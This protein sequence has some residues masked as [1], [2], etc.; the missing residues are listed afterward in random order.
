MRIEVEISEDVTEPEIT[1]KCRE[2]TAVVDRLVAA[3]QM[4]DRQIMVSYKGSI[5][6]LGLGEILY[7]ESVDGKSFVY[8]K[9]KI[10]ESSCKLYE[11]EERLE[12]YMF[13]RISKSAIVNLEHIKSMKTWLERRL[14]ITM[15]NG[16]QLIASRQYAGGIKKLLGVQGKGT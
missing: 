13:V 8:T 7:I 6:P 16:E 1:I 4:I 5:T 15:E 10:Y 9:E 11:L 14:F 3:L 12:A 2:K